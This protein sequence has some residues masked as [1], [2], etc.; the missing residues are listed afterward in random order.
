MPWVAGIDGCRAG[1][2]VV[3]IEAPDTSPAQPLD[4]R[5]CPT[6]E[7]VLSLQPTPTVMAV[8]MPIGL[9]ET[10]SLAGAPAIDRRDGCWGDAPAVSSAHRA[11]PSWRRRNTPRCEAMA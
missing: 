11:G 9:L 4:V 5:L 8:D 10:P 1:W 2:V 6:F 3:L 7:A